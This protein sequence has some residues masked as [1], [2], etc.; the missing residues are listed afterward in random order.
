MEVT[1]GKGV[2]FL[3]DGPSE[4]EP[5]AGTKVAVINRTFWMRNSLFL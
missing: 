5:A 4:G 1:A 3:Y 2:G